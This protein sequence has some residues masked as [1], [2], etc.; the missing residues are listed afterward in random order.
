MKIYCSS[1]KQPTEYISDR[2]KFCSGCGT[3]FQGSSNASITIVPQP[4]LIQRPS[5]KRYVEVDEEE[6]EESNS[7]IDL[8]N[9]SPFKLDSFSNMRNT[10]KFGRLAEDTSPKM[11]INRPKGKKISKKDFEQQW[12]DEIIKKGSNNVGGE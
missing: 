8:S 3:P 2:P 10:E 9:M 1:C 7:N 11:N 12:R 6:Y 4:I 5:R